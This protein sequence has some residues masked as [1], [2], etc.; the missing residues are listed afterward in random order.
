MHH[1]R[2]TCRDAVA[3]R[4]M[5]PRPISIVDGS[6]HRL[7]SRESSFCFCR[8]NTDRLLRGKVSF[9]E[10]VMIRGFMMPCVRDDIERSL[11]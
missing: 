4:R 2:S 11:R 6:R 10:W 8:G 7:S 5:I 1:H 3:C 9:D